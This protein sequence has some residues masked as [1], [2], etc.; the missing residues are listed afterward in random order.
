MS[1]THPT[2]HT[3]ASRRAAPSVGDLV[4]GVLAR[5]GLADGIAKWRAV[6]EWEA[7]AGEALARHARPSRVD[8]DTLIIQ[9]ENSYV[10][11]ELSHRKAELL[12]RLAA[13]LGEG[14]IRD[15][16]LVLGRNQE[17]RP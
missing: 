8:G 12:E 10:M 5:L 16:R 11:F 9:A 1:G 14:T 7:I 6:V 17:A 15:V 13:H 4:P 3:P 2:P